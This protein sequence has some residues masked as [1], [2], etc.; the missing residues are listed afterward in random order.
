MDRDRF[1][2]L[3]RLFAAKQSRRA[4]MTALLSAAFLSRTADGFAKSGKKK[5]RDND[6]GKGEARRRGRTNDR[7]NGVDQD[8]DGADTAADASSLDE[9]SA[10]EVSAERRP[11]GRRGRQGKGRGSG[12]DKGKKHGNGNRRGKANARDKQPAPGEVA[13]ATGDCRGEGHPCE[14][15]QTCCD[16]LVCKVSGP[17]AA[18]RCTACPSGQIACANECIPACTASDQCHVGGECDPETGACTNPKAADGTSCNDDDPCTLGGTCQNGTCGGAP[19]DCSG[20][21]D[22]CN[23]GVCRQS[24]GACVKRPK[25]DGTGCNA[26][27]DSCT[28]GDSCRNG[29]CTPG[30][31]VSCGHLD[32]ACNRGVCQP[33]GGCT[34]EPRND[35]E[36][37]LAGANFCT[38]VGACRN[39]ACA[40]GP[41]VVCTASDACHA[42]GVCDPATGRCSNP[43]AP[44]GTACGNN[45]RC[46]T[47]RCIEPC[48]AVNA[49]C[50]PETDTCCD[51]EGEACFENAAC[52][53][54]GEGRCCRP[55]GAF[56]EQPCDCCG[57]VCAGGVCCVPNQ[58]C[59]SNN[60]CCDGQE[61]IDFVCQSVCGT[62][63]A[64]CGGG[65]GSAPCCDGFRCVDNECWPG[66]CTPTTEEC[67]SASECCPDGVITCASASPG[68]NRC[69]HP[70]NQTCRDTDEC[71]GI[72][73]CGPQSKCCLGRPS[74]SERNTTGFA[75]CDG[76]EHDCCPGLRCHP[77]SKF[78]CVDEGQPVPPGG[79]GFVECCHFAEQDGVCTCHRRGET[80]SRPSPSNPFLST[81]CDGLVCHNNICNTPCNGFLGCNP[82]LPC[83]IGCTFDENTGCCDCP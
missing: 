36:L 6:R 70:H 75:I 78:C 46:D 51:Q 20:E 57:G 25:A 29:V 68:G 11:G 77:Q 79:G 73:V 1:D 34:R 53:D 12:R 28:A 54:A 37:C 44:D 3:V 61:C 52:S 35:G 40:A 32:D 18:E 72:E 65:A 14:G 41:A 56:C 26:D 13:A 71:C 4:A 55:E 69:C 22:V 47:G 76:R 15:N 60:E 74:D 2:A 49:V 21:G 81:C 8:A 10:G 24:D 19:K 62:D 83:C 38:D 17:G 16:G 63:R 58:Q 67:S 23:D 33:D 43:V 45:G 82:S 5:R 59:N 7:E 39:G 42:A 48:L 9:S 30:A 66:T 64:F 50:N 27:D 31:G 80:C